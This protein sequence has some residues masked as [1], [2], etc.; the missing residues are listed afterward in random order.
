MYFHENQF[1]YP[2][3]PGAEKERDVQFGWSQA[4]S[5][6]A[7]DLILF[8]SKYNLE[9]F[10]DGLTKCIKLMPKE[11]QT[12]GM[13]QKIRSKSQVLYYPLQIDKIPTRVRLSAV[14]D[15]L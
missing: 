14:A 2:V 12:L 10:L 8:N 7:A 15:C 9:S 6:M 3:Q 1:E 5:C 13:I 11:Q 4:I